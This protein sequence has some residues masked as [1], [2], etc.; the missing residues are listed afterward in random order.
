[1][2]YFKNLKASFGD[3]VEADRNVLDN[4]MATRSDGGIAL[5]DTGNAEGSWHVYNLDTGK[6]IKRNSLHVL[7]MP[8]IVVDH[9]DQMAQRDRRSRGGVPK[10]EVGVGRR[11]VADEDP[12][13]EIDTEE[14]LRK[15]YNDYWDRLFTPTQQDAEENDP[16]EDLYSDD[17]TEGY[18]TDDSQSEQGEN[19]NPDPE[20]V[21]SSDNEENDSLGHAINTGENQ[22]GPA[23]VAD[24]T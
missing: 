1:M 11:E 7:P 3:Y 14:G 4:T 5:F 9:L 2:D 17:S 8:Q 16:A 6:V 20:G 24:S 13:E 12:V 15:I 22:D 18:Y 21:E 10:F 19:L 23:F